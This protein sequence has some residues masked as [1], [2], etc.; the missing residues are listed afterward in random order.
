MSFKFLKNFKTKIIVFITIL[1]IAS[2]ANYLY[3]IKNVNKLYSVDIVLK[4]NLDIFR[5]YQIIDFSVFENQYRKK[6]EFEKKNYEKMLKGNIEKESIKNNDY[7]ISQL[8]KNKEICKALGFKN[9]TPEYADCLLKL[10]EVTSIY[11]QQQGGGFF[12]IKLNQSITTDVNMR[13]VIVQY[14]SVLEIFR[15][16]EK[17][18][19]T[20]I[21][22]IIVYEKNGNIYLKEM[23][24]DCDKFKIQNQGRYVF[25]K[26][27]T[28]DPAK[29]LKIV[30]VNLTMIWKEVIDSQITD[31]ALKKYISKN[32]NRNVD[33]LIEVI[34]SKVSY[35]RNHLKSTIILNAS[36]IFIFAA[37]L[38]L[39]INRKKIL[40]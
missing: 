37:Y 32:N 15:S 36:L 28:K 10:A 27:I 20:L 39:L 2:A 3:Q 25:V 17:A 34:T 35:T 1:F 40:K 38:I 26:C 33:G 23:G 31:T 9:A 4:D 21:E 24:I 5:D 12:N 29:I 6:L 8:K 11:A 19:R 22:D 30:P 13:P 18:L 16:Y 14:Q 7:K